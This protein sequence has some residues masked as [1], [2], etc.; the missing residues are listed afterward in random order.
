MDIHLLPKTFK[1]VDEAHLLIRLKQDSQEAFRE[2]YDLYHRRLY[3]F[4]LQYC[5]CT[6]DAEEIVEDVFVRLWLARHDIREERSPRS[7]LFVIARRQIITAF[8]KRAKSPE[9][10]AFTAAMRE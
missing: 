4:C 9:Y 6:E 8:R 5:K 10:A 1:T 2:I 3:A 7:L